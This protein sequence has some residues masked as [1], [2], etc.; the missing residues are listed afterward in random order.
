MK[1][2]LNDALK[3]INGSDFGPVKKAELQYHYGADSLFMYID[4]RTTGKANGFL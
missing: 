1:N 4:H 2:L 3:P